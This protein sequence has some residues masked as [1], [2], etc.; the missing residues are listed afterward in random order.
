MT[1]TTPQNME[2]WLW[3]I[4]NLRLPVFF[5]AAADVSLTGRGAEIGAGTA[6]LS[7]V[8]SK[9][10]EVEHITAIEIDSERL[11]LAQEFFRTEFAGR[12]N[13]ISYV[14]GDFHQLPFPEA[15]L[16]FVVCD[17]ALHHTDHL[18]RLLTE[19]RR[20]LKP[21]GLLLAIREPVLPSL[22]L[23]GWWRKTS[24]G[25]RQRLLGDIEHAYTMDE[26][27]DAFRRLGFTWRA[28]PCFITTT[29]KER[30]VTKFGRFNG[31]LFGRY[32]FIAHKQL[33]GRQ[34]GTGP[35]R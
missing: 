10:P 4:R 34:L 35:V 25:R 32:Y 6:W 11:K 1:A 30:L 13:K 17:A 3:H 29:R 12:Q 20:I 19:I 15:S 24:F 27:A 9:R 21:G 7:A 31:L 23:L 5:Q 18:D 26:W 28:V 8:I 16:D 2:R 22:P 33:A 14:R